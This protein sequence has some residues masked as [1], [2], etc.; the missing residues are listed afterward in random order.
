MLL[1]LTQ[2]IKLATCSAELC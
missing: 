2:V 1:S